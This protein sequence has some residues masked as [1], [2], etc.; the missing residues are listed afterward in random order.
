MTTVAGEQVFISLTIESDFGTQRL[1][2]CGL[3]VTRTK[4]HAIV[5]AP[6]QIAE[7][8]EESDFQWHEVLS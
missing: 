2:V 3:L 1:N 6:E 4:S 7:Y 8:P 5:C